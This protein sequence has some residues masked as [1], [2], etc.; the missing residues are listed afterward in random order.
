MDDLISRQAAI[1]EILEC[2]PSDFDNEYE[3]GYDDGLRKAV[4]K[5]KHLPS[6]QP[7][8]KRGKWY[9]VFIDGL[10]FNGLVF[11]CSECGKRSAGRTNFCAYCGAEMEGAND[12]L[13]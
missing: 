1:E 3:C 8:R 5:L 9:N 4:H 7:E 6:A 13:F 10:D 12:A 11:E 2:C